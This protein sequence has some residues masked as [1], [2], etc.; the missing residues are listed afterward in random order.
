[1]VMQIPNDQRLSTTTLSR[2][3][4]REGD[5]LLDA[6]R[7]GVKSEGEARK[8]YAA[9]LARFQAAAAANFQTRLDNSGFFRDPAP[10]IERGE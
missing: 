9:A 8:A 4:L 7:A 10:Q 6:Y 2:N 3:L 5:R 1:M